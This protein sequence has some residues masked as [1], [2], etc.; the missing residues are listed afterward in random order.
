MPFVI[1]PAKPANPLAEFFGMKLMIEKTNKRATKIEINV[2]FAIAFFFSMSNFP[3]KLLVDYKQLENLSQLII[4]LN[5]I[6]LIIFHK[7]VV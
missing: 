5:I 1:E 6:K 7:I 3:F 4:T 2:I